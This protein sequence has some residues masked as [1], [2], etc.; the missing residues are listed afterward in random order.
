MGHVGVVCGLASEAQALG[1]PAAVSGARAAAAQREASR[2]AREGAAAL[3]SV[4]LA[5]ALAEGLQPGDLLVPARVV[6]A[7]GRTHGAD[8]GLAGELGFVLDARSL[9]GSDRLVASVADK[10]A[11]F[12]ATGAV[13]VDMESHAVARAAQAAGLPFLAIRV[14]ADPADTAIPPCAHN[15]IGPDGRVKVAATLRA[16]LRRPQD[17][18]ALLA[19][20]RASAVAH[21]RLRALGLA[22]ALA[23]LHLAP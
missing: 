8:A 19:L 12:A 16:L 2:L 11:L 20:G 15:S 4:G 23:S 14:I 18:P 1:V 7:G 3:L 21:A 17:L 9:L 22:R 6:E 10:A 5:G 13:A